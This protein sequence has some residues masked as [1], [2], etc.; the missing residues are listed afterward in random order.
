LPYLHAGW[1]GALA[2]GGITWWV[3]TYVFE[4]GGANRELTEG[5]T[6]LLAAVVLVYVGFWLHGKTNAKRWREFVEKK[7]KGALTGRALWALTLVAFLAVYREVF[8]TV[9]FYQALWMQT[10]EGEQASVWG[11]IGVGLGVLVVLGMLILRFSVRLPLKPFFAVNS[12]IMFILAV[13]FTGHGVAALQKTGWIPSDTLA[14]LPSVELLGIYP[15]VETTVAQLL[16]GGLVAFIYLRDRF[17]S[18]SAVAA[19]S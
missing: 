18:N 16:V 12:A 10:A 4:I 15:T 19:N 2:L 5:L 11:G 9:L 1:G 6:A 14:A 8:E 17:S 13:A 7:I 3:S